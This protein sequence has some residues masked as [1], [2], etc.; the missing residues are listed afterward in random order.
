MKNKTFINI[1][2]QEVTEGGERKVRYKGSDG[3]L[4]DIAANKQLPKL[5]IEEVRK[6]VSITVN[7]LQN[8]TVPINEFVM[9]YQGA[10]FADFQIV[11][12]NYTSS[13]ANKIYFANSIKGTFNYY[14][15]LGNSVVEFRNGN[16][17][18][19]QMS[20]SDF[21]SDMAA[22]KAFF[23]RTI[24]TIIDQLTPYYFFYFMK[25]AGMIIK[26]CRFTAVEQHVIVAKTDGTRTDLGSLNRSY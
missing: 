13:S 16:T 8:S 24:A 7:E 23:E 10:K 5:T 25:N 14:Y 12:A 21:S 19:D 9:K 20:R 15:D 26:S 17:V 22:V 4:H 18:L 1:Q 2:P 3:K 11:N 6:T